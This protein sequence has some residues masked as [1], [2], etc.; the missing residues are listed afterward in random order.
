MQVSR[1]ICRMHTSPDSMEER[2]AEEGTGGLGK[3]E[4]IPVDLWRRVLPAE[5]AVLMRSVCKMARAEM[6]RVGELA[7]IVI[8]KEDFMRDI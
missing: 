6:E 1:F 2:A 8:V 4:M 5:R 3:L 7:T